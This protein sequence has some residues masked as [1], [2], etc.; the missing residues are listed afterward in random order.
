MIDLILKGGVAMYPIIL[1]SIVVLAVVLER[2]WVLRRNRVIPE[3]FIQSLEN[4]ISQKKISE[5]IFLCQGNHSSIARV[6]FAGLK[7]VGKGLWLVK[8]SIEERGARE[9]VI[10]EKRVAILSTIATL[11]PL[12]G[13]F[14]TVSGVIKS[15]NAISIH[16]SN[17]PML[18]AG[19]I[20]EALVAT[21]S[22]LAVAIPALICHRFLKDK[23]GALI[24][25]MEEYSIKIVE[26]LG[27]NSLTD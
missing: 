8:E 20:A 9:A 21:A 11:G 13:L 5:A 22:G 4:L 24:F 10:L 1:C 14:G 18:L 6:I 23:A 27:N 26:L 7:N 3:E 12:L 16:G 17:D 15:F 2:L 25:D 19:G